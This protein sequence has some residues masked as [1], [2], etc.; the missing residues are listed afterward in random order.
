LA[1]VVLCLSAG[2]QAPPTIE[3]ELTKYKVPL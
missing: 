2:A 3:A 1:S